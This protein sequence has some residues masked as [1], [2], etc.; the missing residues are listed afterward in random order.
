MRS[1][2]LPG[3]ARRPSR[4]HALA[5]GV[6]AVAA[7]ALAVS[8]AG[9]G[10]V[11]RPEPPGSRLAEQLD[12]LRGA[13][14]LVRAGRT[15]VGRD[16]ALYPTAFGRLEAALAGR[17]VPALDRQALADLVR[18]DMLDTPAWQAH[19]VCLAMA[20]SS[21]PDAGEVLE[22]AGLRRR[23]VSEA[24]AYLRAPDRGDD[25][26]T[27]LATRAAFLRTATCLG[28]DDEVPRT[29]LDRL[30][31]DTARAGQP[32]PALYAVE[33]LR[34]VGVTARATR[35][36]RDADT[37]ATADCTAVDPVQR[38]AWALLRRQL[39]RQ[40][41]TCLL[42]ALR[43]PDPQTRWLARRALLL[44]ADRPASSLPTA[45]GGVRPDGLVAKAPTQL[46][47][48][49]ATYE[50]ARALTASA[51]Q[52]HTPQWL[53]KRL[54][55]LGSDPA[56]EASDRILLAM[57]CH[58]LSLACGPQADKGV[59][60]AAALVVPARL[61]EAN[62]RSWYGTMA[63]RAE[64]GLGCPRTAVDLPAGEDTVL[65]DTSLRIVVVLADAG[66]TNRARQLTAH[67]DLMGQ[68]QQALRDGKLATASD[69]VQAALASDR[70]IPQAWWDGLPRLLDRY[71][72]AKFPDLYADAPG[73][74]ASAEATR[75]AYYLLA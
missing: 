66:C 72:D 25:A 6:M 26:L 27:S 31:A 38:A 40:T 12:A 5:A 58:R 18:T 30:A 51:R 34:D 14:D 67:A 75:A 53:R 56:L 23:A 73:G 36:L 64:F 47:T 29:T 54:R 32:A 4:R 45:V 7:G 11:E 59:K 9:G 24:L 33:A 3:G 49:T 22:R 70:S 37:A 10:V 68:A 46:G 17:Q 43:D 55:Q 15:D 44:A 63:A 71:R 57:T 74:A 42:P 65:S 13:N 62:Q 16:P 48:L 61:T 20:D 52:A 41:Q 1:S 21:N 69:A 2:L 8:M 35:A 19:Y 60:E 50:A 39:T 28:A